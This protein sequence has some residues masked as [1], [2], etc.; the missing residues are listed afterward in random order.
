[1]QV[2]KDAQVQLLLKAALSSNLMV[3]E[4]A[5]NFRQIVS[6]ERPDDDKNAIIYMIAAA[7]DVSRDTLL[8]IGDS[9]QR[10][11]IIAALGS[12]PLTSPREIEGFIKRFHET[13]APHALAWIDWANN[14]NRKDIRE[15]VLLLKAR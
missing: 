7:I 14:Q 1:M 6:G 15:M 11:V 4:A 8:I 5:V 13:L 3:D 12:L 2:I 10:D 9:P